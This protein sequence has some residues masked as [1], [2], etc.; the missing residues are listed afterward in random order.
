VL[1]GRVTAPG[2]AGARQFAN[3]AYRILVDAWVRRDLTSL[4]IRAPR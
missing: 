1:T 3:P 2:T 4:V